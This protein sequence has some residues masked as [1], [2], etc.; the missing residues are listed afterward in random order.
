VF[1]PPPA[2]P[3]LCVAAQRATGARPGARAA[4][5][6]QLAMGTG[7]R[8]LACTWR[9]RRGQRTQHAAWAPAAGFAKHPPGWTRPR[10]LALAAAQARFPQLKLPRSAL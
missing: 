7:L 6:L 2:G 3:A 1:Q 4:Q 8:C 10:A 5:V 9:A